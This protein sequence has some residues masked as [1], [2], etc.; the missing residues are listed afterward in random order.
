MALRIAFLMMPAKSSMNS[1]EVDHGSRQVVIMYFTPSLLL[2]FS[3]HGWQKQNEETSDEDFKTLRILQNLALIYLTNGKIRH[4]SRRRDPCLKIWDWERHTNRD[5]VTYHKRFRYFESASRVSETHDFL[6]TIRHPFYCDLGI[7][8]YADLRYHGVKLI[9]LLFRRDFITHRWWQTSTG[10]ERTYLIFLTPSLSLKCSN[11]ELYWWSFIVDDV[12]II[13]IRCSDSLAE[14]W[15]RSL[16]IAVL[17]ALH[18]ST[19]LFPL[20]LTVK[21]G[22]NVSGPISWRTAIACS[23]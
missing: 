18:R 6:V 20:I 4:S 22:I 1:M 9:Y 19:S 23:S 3:C 2:G 13:G 15:H 14:S 10:V 12:T 8:K 16:K 17:T 5:F 11:L 21:H 7:M